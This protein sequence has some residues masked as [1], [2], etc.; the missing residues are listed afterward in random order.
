MMQMPAMKLPPIKFNMELAVKSAPENADITYEISILEA[1]VGE[2]PGAMPQMVEMLKTA[3]EGFKGLTGTGVM[4]NRGQ[5]KE[6]SFKSPD[7]A[8]AQFRQLVEQVKEIL[9]YV[10]VQ[11]PEEPVG[12]GA[13]WE[14]K[15]PVKA[16]GIT[17]NQTDQYELTA[18]E[19]DR[20]TLKNVITQSASNQTME[21]PAM[22]GMKMNL[23]KLTGSG[24]AELVLDL[25]QITSGSG[26]IDA[27]SETTV[28]MGDQKQTM[29]I[30]NQ[31]TIRI[32]GK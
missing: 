13:K 19:G 5:N 26:T 12:V 31:A 8:D 25:L 32:E 15:R 7:D 28:S 14:V 27:R 21:N 4:S 20:L 29:T 11:L 6:L 22:P 16:Q 23:S 3:M 10:L 30:K 24:T 1:S 9:T 2:E 17:M 18:V